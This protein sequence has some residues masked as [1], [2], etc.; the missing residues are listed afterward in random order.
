MLNTG[1]FHAKETVGN[2]E[3]GKNSWLAV[4]ENFHFK[5]FAFVF[6]MKHYHLNGRLELSVNVR[7]TGL[8][9]KSYQ[10]GL[11]FHEF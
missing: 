4:F 1:I 10:E 11:A 3:S 2:F 9:L 6:L 8:L 7:I 5:C